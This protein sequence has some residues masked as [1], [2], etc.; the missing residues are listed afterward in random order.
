[1]KVV[2]SLRTLW[3]FFLTWVTKYITQNPLLKTQH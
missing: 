1:M 3:G 2:M